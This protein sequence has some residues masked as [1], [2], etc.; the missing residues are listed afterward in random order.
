MMKNSLIL[1]FSAFVAV[2]CGGGAGELPD[3]VAVPVPQQN[4]RTVEENSRVLVSKGIIHSANEVNVFSRIEGQ[5]QDVKLREGQKVHKGE[6]LFTLDDMELKG[7]ILLSESTLE[8]AQVRMEEILIGQGYKRDEFDSAPEKVRSYAMVKSGLNVAER[9]LE[10]NK[11]KL[12]RT[13]ITAAQ[14]GLLTGIKPLPY[15]FVKPGETLCN[16]VDPDNLVVEFSI[17][18]TEIRRFSIGQTIDV[19]A[20]AYSEVPHMAVIKSIGSV[21]DESGMVKLV[22]AIEDPSQLLPGMTAI[23][24]L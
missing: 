2:S 13:V 12:K 20:I 17:L 6:V 23:V 18:E 9:E 24:N 15:S 11:E 19:R 5:L 14:S 1:L 10:I 4:E 8:Q 22:A 16:I 21:V 3:S 7:K